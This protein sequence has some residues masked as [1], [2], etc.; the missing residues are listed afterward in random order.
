MNIHEKYVNRCI[1]LA[2]NGLGT[3]SPNPMVGSVVVHDGVIIGE[4]WHRKAGEPHAEVHAINAVK[5]RS[6]LEKATIYVSLEPC[7]H[8]GKTPP[9]SDLIIRSGIRNVVIGIIDPFDAVAGRGIKKL[10]EAGCNVTVGVLEEECRELNKRFFTFHNKR[11][12]YIIL[13]WAEST[14]RYISPEKREH[15]APVW[16]SNRYSRQLVHRW[17][18]EEQAVLV[19]TETALQDN[20][21]L[22]TRDWYGNSPVRIVL[23][24][25]LRLPGEM[26]LFD[27]SVKTIVLTGQE[28]RQKKN[29]FFE[30]IG[31]GKDLAGEICSVLYGHNIQSLIV[32][33]GRQTLQA[34]IDADIWDEARVFQGNVMLNGGTPAPLLKGTVAGEYGI[35]GDRLIYVK[36]EKH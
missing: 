5:D 3:T 11:R 35:A 22:N 30:T 26:A 18:S 23:D 33:G 6:L 9:C 2:K 19:G 29:T 31:F 17:R 10:M 7:S 16:I 36:P 20:P 24:R 25:N 8:H 4:G 1:Q 15:R 13:K 34:F 12:P 32:E 27:N 21:A 28:K 14:D